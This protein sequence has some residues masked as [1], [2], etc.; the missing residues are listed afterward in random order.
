MRLSLE[1]AICSPSRGF[2]TKDK[3]GHWLQSYAI[4]TAGANELMA[5]IHPRMPV[6]LHA[7]DYDRWLDREET[8]RLPIDLLSLSRDVLSSMPNSGVARI[9]T[10]VLGSKQDSMA[11]LASAPDLRGRMRKRRES[12]A[13]L[14]SRDIN[15]PLSS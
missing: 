2:G 5:K 6:I 14:R 10:H 15:V 1:T 8:E 13:R 7:R 12:H 4:V 3:D 11:A 9:A